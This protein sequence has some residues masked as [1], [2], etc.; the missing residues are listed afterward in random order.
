MFEGDLSFV[1]LSL[2]LVMTQKVLFLFHARLQMDEI[3][4]QM[5]WTL[6]LIHPFPD[7][8][9]AEWKDLRWMGGMGHLETGT[10]GE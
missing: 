6:N 9:E 4:A 2:L 10:I 8:S 1:D 7:R 5:H 3:G